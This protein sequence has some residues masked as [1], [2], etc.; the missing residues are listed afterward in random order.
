[1]RMVLSAEKLERLAQAFEGGE[2]QQYEAATATTASPKHAGASTSIGTNKPR[3]PREGAGESSGGRSG[4][5]AVVVET[6]KSLAK[7]AVAAAS[8]SIAPPSGAVPAAGAAALPTPIV[9]PTPIR[10]VDP[11]D[12]PTKSPTNTPAGVIMPPLPPISPFTQVK[13]HGY[14]GGL[15]SS[16]SFAP[17]TKQQPIPHITGLAGSG[18][19]L[20]GA[21]VSFP[22]VVGA[23][24]L[25]C[26]L[27]HAGIEWYT[28]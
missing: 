7:K 4:S 15:G 21:V 11:A 13:P 5:P 10:P 25:A 24:L 19:D 8:A 6:L 3:M 18:G 16:V 14:A 28:T 2:G 9:A 26:G 17:P 12:A 27:S 22:F 1:M 20:L 23:C